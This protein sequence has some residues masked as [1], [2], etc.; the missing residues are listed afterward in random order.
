MHQLSILRLIRTQVASLPLSCNVTATGYKHDK[1]VTEETFVFAFNTLV[2][3][4]TKNM[5]EAVLPKSFEGLDTVTFESSYDVSNMIGAT[6]ID[7]LEYITYTKKD[8][9]AGNGGEEDKKE[10]AEKPATF[11]KIPAPSHF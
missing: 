11:A 10:E 5:T 8:A 4:T 7:S 9:K 1:V 3:G 2:D 6:L